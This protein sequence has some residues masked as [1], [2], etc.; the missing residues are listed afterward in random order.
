MGNIKLI[1]IHKSYGMDD[2][3]VTFVKGALTVLT[4]EFTNLCNLVITTAIP[5]QMENSNSYLN[6]QKYKPSDLQ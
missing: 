2:L 5:R 4:M 6:P 1:S 3:N